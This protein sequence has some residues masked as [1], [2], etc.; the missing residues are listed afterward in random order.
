MVTIRNSKREEV[1]FAILSEE[2]RKLI[3]KLLNDMREVDTNIMGSPD[4]FSPEARHLAGVEF[5]QLSQLAEI[6]S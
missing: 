6:F 2:G 4:V 1:I 5:E 3:E